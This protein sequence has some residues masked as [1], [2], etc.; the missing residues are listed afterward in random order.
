MV[1]AVVA[2]ERGSRRRVVD[3]GHRSLR[4]QARSRGVRPVESADDLA[5]DG[6]FDSDAELDDFL[7]AIARNRAA[8]DRWLD[9]AL[10]L[11]YDRRVA[12]VWG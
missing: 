3:P 10:L 7:A 4:E 2:P 8:L 9:R 5:A 6:V 12:T 11:P 1:V